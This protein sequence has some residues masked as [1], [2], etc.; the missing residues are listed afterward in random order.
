MDMYMD[1]FLGLVIVFEREINWYYFND[2]CFDL[3]FICMG[4]VIIMVIVLFK[5][6][7]KIKY[8]FKRFS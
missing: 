2:G 1:Y 7:Y 3:G 6:K 8:Y 5:R 4:N